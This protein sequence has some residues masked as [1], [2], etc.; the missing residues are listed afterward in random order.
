MRARARTP[1]SNFRSQLNFFLAP[2]EDLPSCKGTWFWVFLWFIARAP[3]DTTDTPCQP[4]HHLTPV[5]S[6]AE[7]TAATLQEMNPFCKVEVVGKPG[8]ARVTQS[9]VEGCDA[10]LVCGGAIAEA[11]RI[12]ELCRKVREGW[13][14]S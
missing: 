14:E 3:T 4:S 12:N 9:M 7:G 13:R 8:A 5:R 6:V 10:V 1:T 2:H 11:E